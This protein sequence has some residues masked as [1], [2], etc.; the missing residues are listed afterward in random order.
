M[1]SPVTA[2]SP[3]GEPKAGKTISPLAGKPARK[4]QLV[5]VSHLQAEYISAS[6]V[7]GRGRCRKNNGK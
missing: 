3:N 1:P 7:V 4:E 5:D 6:A 2:K